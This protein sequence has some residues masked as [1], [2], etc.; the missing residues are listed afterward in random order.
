MTLI[1]LM[2]CAY[3]WL[4]LSTA[5]TQAK[6]PKTVRLPA[7]TEQQKTIAVQATNRLRKL[8]S[9]NRCDDAFQDVWSARHIKSGNW[10]SQC[11]S[12]REDLGTW[13]DFRIESATSCDMPKTVLLDGFATFERDQFDVLMCWSLRDSRHPELLFMRMGREGKVWSQMPE[14]EAGYDMPPIHG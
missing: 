12:L 10:K 7:A 5:C 2:L 3:A 9:E 14:M 11:E 8:L 4:C 13:K 1:N 6:H